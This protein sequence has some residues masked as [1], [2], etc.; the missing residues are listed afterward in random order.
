MEEEKLQDLKKEIGDVLWYLSALSNDLG[1]TL[2]EVAEKNLE[3]LKSRQERG[4]VH[5]NGDNR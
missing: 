1:F 3:K 5:G 2:E 4:V